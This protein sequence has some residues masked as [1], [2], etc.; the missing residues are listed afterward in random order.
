MAS[1]IDTMAAVF[2]QQLSLVARRYERVTPGAG[3]SMPTALPEQILYE[4]VVAPVRGQREM[5]FL[6]AKDAQAGLAYTECLAFALE[7]WTDVA[8]LGQAWSFL[9]R[10]HDALRVESMADDAIRVSSA[11]PPWAVVDGTGGPLDDQALLRVEL[12][13]AIDPAHGP[14]A[15]ATLY[16]GPQDRH[17][18]VIAVHHLVADGWSL[19]LVLAE[20]A[21][22][23]NALRQGATPALPPARSFKDYAD[24]LDRQPPQ[25]RGATPVRDAS[26]LILPGDASG[27][28][29]EGFQ[30]FRLHRRSPR[31]PGQAEGTADGFFA[32]VRRC[33]RTLG[34]SPVVVLLGSFV[35]LLGRLS[36]QRRLRIGLPFAGHS[37]AEMPVMV[38]MAS[39]VMPLE[40]DLGADPTFHYVLRAVSES[41]AQA[42]STAAG[43]FADGS[44]S[45]SP[46]SVLFNIDPGVRLDFD[47]LRLLPLPLPL[48]HVKTELFLNLLEL[49]GEVLLDF[50]CHA[51]LASPARAGL[52]LDGWL[53]LL[54]HAL[55]QPDAPIATLTLGPLTG[56]VA[57]PGLRLL[58]GLGGDAAVGIPA[59]LWR[60]GPSTGFE[61]T[62]SLAHVEADGR[63]QVLGLA[64]R[65]LRLAD[66]W[67]DLDAVE[68]ALQS[69][70][71]VRQAVALVETGALTAF[72]VPH[73]AQG[74]RPAVLDGHV[75]PLLAGHACPAAYV[76]LTALPLD[77]GGRP[78]GAALRA[79]ASMRQPA[80]AKVAPRN[81]LETRLAGLWAQVLGLSAPPGVTDDFFVLGGHSLKAVALVNSIA[82]DFGKS[83]P[84]GAF[85]RAPTIAALAELLASAHEMDP[86][87]RRVPAE[88]SAPS[89]AQRRLW[90]LEQLNPGQQAYNMGFVLRRT[91][92]LSPSGLI[93]TFERLAERHESLRS[94]LVERDA[95]PWMQVAQALVPALPVHDLRGLADAPARMDAVAQQVVGTPFD[96]E[97]PP[98]WR[99][100]LLR[101]D[102]GDALVVGL[103]H[104]IGD[105]WSIAVWVR[106]FLA[107]LQQEET[108]GGAPAL[109]ALEVQYGD[110]AAWHNARV[111]ANALSLA[112]WSDRLADAPAVLQLPTCRPRQAWNAPTSARDA[113]R[114]CTHPLSS[115]AVAAM[116]TLCASR[117]L[118]G[119][120]VLVAA[121]RL[122]LWARTGQRDAVIGT[123]HA[124][125]D[126]P[127]L[128]DQI[129][130]FVNTLPLRD[131]LVPEASFFDLLDQTRQTVLDAFEHAEMPFNVL[132]ERL[133]LPR[134]VGGNPLFEVMLTMDDWQDIDTWVDQAG[135]R[136]HEVE[137]PVSQFELT[138]SGVEHPQGLE[139]RMQYRTALWD[140]AIIEGWL[141]EV[142]ALLGAACTDPGQCLSTLARPADLV[143]PDA[144][145]GVVA[146]FE[147]WRRRQ[148]Q[149]VAVLG[150]S[151][152][153]Y[154]ALGLAVDG[155]ARR[156]VQDGVGAVAG[157]EEVV[158][159]LVG[160][161]WHLPVATLGVMKAGAAVLLLDAAYPDER[162]SFLLRDARCTWLVTD[163]EHAERAGQWTQ[164]G[165]LSLLRLDAAPGPTA[166]VAL[167]TC[168]PTDL[169][170]IVYTS[171]ST[172]QP[173]GVMVEQGALA[174]HLAGMTPIVGIT[175]GDRSL[176][177]ASA[178]VDAVIEQMLL[179]LLNGAALHVADQERYSPE[180]LVQRWR[181]L[182]LNIL[183]LPPVF[184]GELIALGQRDADTVRGLMLKTLLVGGEDMTPARVAGWYALPLYCARLVNAYGPTEATITP[185]AAWIAPQAAGQTR[186][187]IGQPVGRRRARVVRPDGSDAPAGE[188]GELWLGGAS[189]ARGYLH[190]PALS[191]Q[192]FVTTAD[193]QRWYRTGDLA[194]W[195]PDAQLE[196]LGRADRQVKLRG[197]RI[198]PDEIE[199]ALRHCFDVVDAAVTLEHTPEGECL[200]AWI[201]A[202]PGAALTR[203]EVVAQLVHRL[204]AHMVPARYQCI[205]HL[206]V[207][208]GGKL[209]RAALHAQPMRA[210]QDDAGPNPVTLSPTVQV[211]C[212]LLGEVL[213]V[214]EV[215]PRDNFFALGGHSLKAVQVL[216]RVRERLGVALSLRDLFASATVA[217]LA[218]IADGAAPDVTAK[219]TLPTVS[220][221][222]DLPA[223][224]GQRR[225]WLLQ[226]R[227]P[228]LVAF[229][230]VAGL[231]ITGALD[232]PALAAACRAVVWRHEVL[233]TRLVMRAG[234]LV[235]DILPGEGGFALQCE[236]TDTE[237]QEHQEHQEEAV[238]AEELNRPFLLESELPLRMR[239]LSTRETKASDGWRHLLVINVHHAAFDGWSANVMFSDLAV[240]YAAARAGGREGGSADLVRRSGLPSLTLQYADHA[241][242]QCRAIPPAHRRY[243]L[244]RFD[245]DDL[246]VLALPCDRP[247]PER[248]SG[249]GGMVVQSFGA[250][251]SQRLHALARQEGV[252]LFAVMAALTMA[253]LHGLSGSRDLILGTA[254][255]G[256][257]DH[258]LENQIGFYVNMLPLRVRIDPSDS[259]RT[260][261]RQMGGTAR[262]ALQHQDYP[263]DELVEALD[264]ARLPGRQPLFDVVLI[265]Q[266]LAP[267]HLDLVDAQTHLVHDR[268]VS[269]KYDLMYM[270]EGEEVLDLHLEYALDLF[271]ESTALRMARAM[272]E[273]A[274]AVVQAPDQV[275]SEWLAPP[276]QT[277]PP[278]AAHACMPLSDDEW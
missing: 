273:L 78:D 75:R 270:V 131:T 211:L 64:D 137:L 269:A 118:T 125:R 144:S 122:W 29:G 170:Y 136:V 42:R 278:A 102:T 232:V 107:L 248:L 202:A 179:P 188:A 19:G 82:R 157:R 40:V 146:A 85:F 106:D 97:T 98:L 80:Q 212:A 90:L 153:S 208:Q 145:A 9:A 244:S 207:T 58:D 88:W 262:E 274:A 210:L 155:L 171:G 117:G 105:N 258:R 177:F 77:R 92:P 257:E 255:A 134:S 129:G 70:P 256:R 230:M 17:V 271:D 13:K 214:A 222:Q 138:L 112:Y 104:A 108:G 243:W 213:Q 113:G 63:V 66:G 18:L 169:A 150:P 89:H 263:F 220:R 147:V 91:R 4:G 103:H 235:Q 120:M 250:Q 43:L 121:W 166:S 109:P 193:G 231:R 217:D 33:A 183:D 181:D 132:A 22:V 149:A 26:R 158:A 247:R 276:V 20:L 79:D 21:T 60:Q 94:T 6:L 218:A 50:D 47:G 172:G 173:K 253:Q 76:E 167:P 237:R 200:L 228:D 178:G 162:L 185:T 261:V 260:L 71:S 266:N 100:A 133:Q 45:V 24:W 101:L 12:A 27:P 264:P 216:A 15:R 190:Q 233:R 74:L 81:A 165:A 86:I 272:T 8:A 203:A 59:R 99:C 189:L 111:A 152:L 25:A 160:R 46:V 135:C 225:L 57:Q 36:G 236:T 142:D 259:M 69:H 191:D 119:F 34:V 53:H 52:W 95:A 265:L 55:D 226:A 229:N 267:M 31:L 16:R 205:D 51:G 84:V 23:Y 10:R 123:L 30:G 223:S 73:I 224:A 151:G 180:A 48:T 182:D 44:G 56:V 219:G 32:R 252:T 87:P 114:S 154:E 176:V 187:P 159:V 11:M 184:W 196:F 238:L 38:G 242:W 14:L 239:L 204:P 49:N 215:R 124:G 3:W 126:H 240:L 96:L 277:H 65:Y 251:T 199:D 201:V 254:V 39:A 195:R 83:V 148:P 2:E 194:R 54:G 174:D 116:Q 1:Q 275:L 110:Y 192:K 41:L 186:I 128:A 246:P 241:H 67:V 130:F 156:L 209:D 163:A 62:G 139:L 61:D 175:P 249:R 198:E 35:V 28:V 197:F 68:Q 245:A 206:P 7:G 268:S 127:A 164:D 168:R 143:V 115:R 37:F 161:S 227:Q 221:T 141:R 72:V 5:L 93:T 140:A 234:S